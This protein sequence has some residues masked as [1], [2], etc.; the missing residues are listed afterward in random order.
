MTGVS[1]ST[2]E[3]LLTTVVDGRP[4][5]REGSPEPSIWPLLTALATTVLFVGS[6]FDEWWIVWGAIPITIC[7]IGW[8]WPQ[9]SHSKKPEARSPDVVPPGAL[10]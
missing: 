4:D 10:A 8:F 3:V 9:P 2:R 5:V 6:I 7:L 1:E